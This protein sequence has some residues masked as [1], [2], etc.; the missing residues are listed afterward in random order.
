VKCN[1]VWTKEKEVG[2]NGDV[3]IAVWDDEKDDD[4]RC[5]GH[6]HRMARAS[7][8]GCNLPES[9]YMRPWVV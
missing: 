9:A 6:R 5:G 3:L 2:S 8:M 7:D 4:E 1:I